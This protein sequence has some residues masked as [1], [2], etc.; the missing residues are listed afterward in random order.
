MS[1][2]IHVERL[3][4][5]FARKPALVDLALS[6]Q[7]GE[8]VAL[9]GAS[10][11]GKS[12]LLRHLAGLACCDRSNGGR[13]E[14]LGREVQS[15]GR[16][17]GKVRH[18]RSDIGYIFQQFNLV[19]RLSVLDNV[20][21]GCL[22]RMP[23]WRGNFGLF[24]ADEKQRAMESLDRVGLA[25]LAAQRASTL[26]GGQQQRVAIARALTQRAEVILAD[27]PIASLDPESARKVMEILADINRTDR[28]TVVVT[29]H[30][31]D[32]A[33]RYCPRAVALKGGRIH[34]DG[35]AHGLSSQFLND[36]YGAD[37]DTSLMI[38]DEGRRTVQPPK[39][40]LARV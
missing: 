4:K 36:L 23:G 13:V 17:N 22:G 40:A 16:L 8:M 7:P 37:V 6:I 24:N 27:E 14:V 1:A 2:A 18:L 32:Y 10:G 39:L 19:N 21:I 29:L 33:V 20:L 38:S 5:T 9:I 26:S 28:K 31:V 35:N 30:Q 25:D 3:N 12:T 11:S 15:S 34:Y